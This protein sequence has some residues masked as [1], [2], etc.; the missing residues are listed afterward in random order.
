MNNVKLDYSIDS[1]HTWIAITPSYPAAVGQYEWTV[2]ETPSTKCFI[3][4]SDLEDPSIHSISTQAFTIPPS[5]VALLQLSSFYTSRTAATIKWEASS[6]GAVDL[7]YMDEN[8]IWKFIAQ[9]VNANRK[10]INWKIPDNISSISIK[11]ASVANNAVQFTSLPIPV[12]PSP[13]ENPVKYHGG[14]YDGHTYATNAA[15]ML[16]VLTPASNAVYR[17]G[18]IMDISW[19]SLH[20]NMLKITFSADSGTTWTNI[21]TTQAAPGKTSW[22]VPPQY[23]DK[24]FIRIMDMDDS[25]Q[26]F[27]LS[28]VFKIEGAYLEVNIKADKP[29]I[30]G[31]AFPIKW[32]QE[33]IQ[34]LNIYYSSSGSGPWKLIAQEVNPNRGYYLWKTTDSLSAVYFKVVSA[35]SN[36]FSSESQYPL[37]IIHTITNTKKYH[38]G[39]YDGAA[40]GTNL[41]AYLQLLSPVAGSNFP[42]QSLADIKW[43]SSGI[44]AIHIHY[45]PDSGVTW[46]AVATNVP[47]ENGRYAWLVPVQF[48]TKGKIRITNTE[49]S[50][51]NAYSD[52]V[53]VISSNTLKLLAPVKLT[54]ISKNAAM[55]IRWQQTG[56][57]SVSIYYSA[58][59]GANWVNIVQKTKASTG[60]F[61]WA[62]NGPENT[63]LRLLIKDIRSGGP[64]D[65]TQSILTISSPPTVAAAKYRGGSY[66][67][68]ATRSNVTVLQLRSPQGGEVMRTGSTFNITWDAY[69]LQD[70]I[71]IELSIDSGR[72][73]TTIV[74][75][76]VLQGIYNWKIEDQYLRK[77]GS[78]Y[79]REMVEVTND[80]CQIRLSSFK[81]DE[82]AVTLNK[83]SFTIITEK[84]VEPVP[85]L[86][87]L[88]P[89]KEDTLVAG[90]NFNITWS[91][92]A[93]TGNVNIDMSAD[94]GKTWITVANAIPNS[95]SFSWAVP[96]RLS[97]TSY[98]G[99]G[100]IRIIA[101][102]VKDTSQLFNWKQ[103]IVTGITDINTRFDLKVYPNPASRFLY[104]SGNF[105]SAKTFVLTLRDLTGRTLYEKKYAGIINAWMEK[106]NIQGVPSGMA[107]ISIRFSDR[108]IVTLPVFIA[109]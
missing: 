100:W 104:I 41:P 19:K 79:G 74:H 63:P 36:A 78:I 12:I 80:K 28:P 49:D 11:I 72:T 44:Q 40:A 98:T 109:R 59:N 1:A 103:S 22:V 102:D 16:Q 26:T 10:Y 89:V 108:G 75:V 66:D 88:K 7:S 53:F 62:V 107:F 27:S 73:W 64:A 65:T 8:G 81:E 70:S 25:T 45:S 58:D 5:Y 84:E 4:I 83:Q 47:A 57:D 52:S 20:V 31:A 46:Q 17:V 2:P 29:V 42:A 91:S 94:S 37:S 3:R 90:N 96:Q 61:N 106:I 38:G 56:I 9:N 95:G 93:I 87:I 67:G 32:K 23:S 35:D 86:E 69:N 43:Q 71:R 76:P 18:A 55:A 24:C 54:S 30:A 68:H 39:S 60:M 92:T 82:S 101:G 51:I 48:T 99:K 97:W 50:T 6:T 85:V 14:S 21:K 15:K 33:G 13:Q 77:A 34:K 105:T